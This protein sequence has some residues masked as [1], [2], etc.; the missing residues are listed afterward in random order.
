MVSVF[1]FKKGYHPLLCCHICVCAV[2]VSAVVLERAC[3]WGGSV[4][5]GERVCVQRGLHAPDA[6]HALVWDGPDAEP[7]P[8]PPHLPDPWGQS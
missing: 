6:Q 8:F 7:E 5:R 1:H 4:R 2:K 3:L